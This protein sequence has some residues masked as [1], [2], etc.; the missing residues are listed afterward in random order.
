MK[1]FTCFLLCIMILAP[2]TFAF[3][4]TPT[5]PT[6]V[7]IRGNA[8]VLSYRQALE[9]I[10]GEVLPIQDMDTFILDMQIQYRELRYQIRQ[11]ER[12]ELRQENIRLLHEQLAALES[13]L[14]NAFWGNELANMQVMQSIN[15][16]VAGATTPEAAAGMGM[17]VQA[18]TAGM[19]QGAGLTAQMGEL[20]MQRAIL[21]NE[22]QNLNDDDLFNLFMGVIRMVQKYASAEQIERLVA[23]LKDRT[24]TVM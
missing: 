21:F 20:E 5:E 4:D 3:A 23:K 1:R 12:G 22:L 10:L 8:V 17:H 6:A 18:A 13:M 15:S 7:E 11:M 14:M 16:M 19:A 24:N 2:T 9:L